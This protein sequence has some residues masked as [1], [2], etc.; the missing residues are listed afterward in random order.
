MD[1][2]KKQKKTHGKQK[3]KSELLYKT[4]KVCNHFSFPLWPN[5][6]VWPVQV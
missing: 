6:P 5:A 2:Q 4:Y 3:E 1:V